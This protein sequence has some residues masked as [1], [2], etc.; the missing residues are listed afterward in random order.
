M[1]A[2]KIIPALLLISTLCFGQEENKNLNSLWD[3]VINKAENYQHYKVI[4]K[5]SL[6]DFWKVL[7]DSLNS[8]KNAL[9]LEKNQVAQQ[10]SQIAQLKSTVEEVKA[11]LEHANLEKDTMNFMGAY[12]DKYTYASLLWALA[13]L[14]LVGCAFLYY[15]F[16]NSNKVTVE[17]IREYE[18]LFNR[19]EDFK[20]NQI[21][22]ERKLKRELQTNI[23]R[24]EELE[25]G[26]HNN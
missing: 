24:I 25:N 8:S 1:K 5:A 13:G 23:N 10:K 22:K 14:L 4:K 17:K 7:Q 2:I 12:I 9:R 18:N 21:E 3:D 11:D 6:E 20:K 16:F 15:L 26:F 19:F